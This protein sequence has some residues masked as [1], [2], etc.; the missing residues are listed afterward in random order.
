M[1]TIHEMN[2]VIWVTNEKLGDG[3]IIA[4][5][6]YGPHHNSVLM[7]GFES[8]EIKFLDT[9]QVRLTRNDTLGIGQQPPQEYTT[10]GNW[11]PPVVPAYE[12]TP[13][14][15]TGTEA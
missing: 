6:D 9:N 3:I 5:I 7:V 2:Q 14:T 4:I 10:F 15:T 12:P 13:I 11:D 1:T 8:G